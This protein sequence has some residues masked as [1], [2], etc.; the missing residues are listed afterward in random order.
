VLNIIV[1]VFNLCRSFGKFTSRKSPERVW[2][3]S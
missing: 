2:R 3:K 1:P